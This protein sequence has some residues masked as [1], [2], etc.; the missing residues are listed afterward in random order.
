MIEYFD[1]VT[2]VKTQLR[3][4]AFLTLVLGCALQ[5]SAPAAE[6]DRAA[7]QRFVT[8]YFGSWSRADFIIYRSLFRPSASVTLLDGDHWMPWDLTQFLNDQERIQS[9]E[10]MEEVP[11]ST[12]IKAFS[13]KA[14][15]VEVAWKLK[16]S[17][18]ESVTGTDWYTLVKE[19]ADWKILNLTFWEDATK[20]AGAADPPA[21]A[22]VSKPKIVV[23]GFDP[24]GGRSI[25]ASSEI[26]RAIVQGFPQWDITFVQVPVIWGAPKKAIARSQTL[27]PSIWIAF[28]EG[29]SGFRIETVARNLRGRSPDNRQKAPTQQKI[30]PNGPDELKL[31]F[32]VEA[33]SERLRSLGYD[34]S[35]SSNA[36]D[37]LCEEM[38][39]S[40]LEAKNSGHSNLKEAIFIH[41]PIKDAKVRV[42]GKDVPFDSDNIRTAAT[43]IFQA[44]AT[45]LKISATQ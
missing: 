22:P 20:P 6:D 41:V 13:G 32:S 14:A 7:I 29:T 30:D 39:Y 1:K 11:L 24:F 35:V 26:A 45:F 3:R 2:P 15:F 19:G 5:F 16:R 38:L 33:L 17:P 34:C 27:D 43:D 25:N 21:E 37:Y 8:T 36:G 28:G 31:D 23:S 42:R 12:Q 4:C 44:I 10:K 18:T 40:L 9:V